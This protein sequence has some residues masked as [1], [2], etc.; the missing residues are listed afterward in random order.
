[1]KTKINLKGAVNVESPVETHL[2]MV[3]SLST[4]VLPQI[5]ETPRQKLL[6]MTHELHDSLLE[7]L[8]AHL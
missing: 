6:N 8:A 2:A 5:I 4:K 7:Y 3:G 1:M